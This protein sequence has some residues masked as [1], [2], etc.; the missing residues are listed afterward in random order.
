MAAES[1]DAPTRAEGLLMGMGYV[2]LI[3]PGGGVGRGGRARGCRRSFISAIAVARDSAAARSA[4]SGDQSARS[5]SESIKSEASKRSTV[6]RGVLAA[7]MALAGPA[8]ARLR[9]PNPTPSA[10]V[11]MPTVYR[12]KG[13]QFLMF[14]DDHA[15]PHVHVRYSGTVA[16]IR[17]G[18][19]NHRPV[20]DV[21]RSMRAPD[22][23]RAMRIVE[24]R[25][26]RFLDA[27]RKIH[28]A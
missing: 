11:Q 25:Q 16:R 17:I 1:G 20:A 28:G 21:S 3:T 19:A 24:T 2:F 15:P 5:G 23:A 13:F 9:L 4:T 12:E 10:T 8:T 6:R 7:V 27:W 14:L 22:I 26:A 18:D